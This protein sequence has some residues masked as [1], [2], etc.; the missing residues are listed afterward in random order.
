MRVREWTVRGREDSEGEGERHT[1]HVRG[2]VDAAWAAEEDTQSEGRGQGEG[3]GGSRGELRQPGRWDLGGCPGHT[4]R[5]RMP[6]QA[7]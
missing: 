7:S 6:Q 2:G 4:E 5:L 1:V 3:R